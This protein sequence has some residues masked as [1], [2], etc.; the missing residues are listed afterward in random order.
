MSI[1]GGIDV[2]SLPLVLCGPVLRRVEANAIHVFVATKEACDV[3]IELHGSSG[4][5]ATPVLSEVTKTRALGKHLHV[6][7]VSMDL[8]QPLQPGDLRSYDVRFAIGT[9][10][11]V[12]LL[13]P[14]VLPAGY[15]SGV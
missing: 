4:S 8:S 10:N 7:L 15:R 3:R 5:G 2:S 11:A 13:D 6:A 1:A 12:G 14:G 9:G